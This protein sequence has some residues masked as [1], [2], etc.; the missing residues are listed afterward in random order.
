MIDIQLTR[1]RWWKKAPAWASHYHAYVIDDFGK[2]RY[3]SYGLT[4]LSAHRRCLNRAI[5]DVYND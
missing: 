5:K 2:V 4:E 3:S 1:L